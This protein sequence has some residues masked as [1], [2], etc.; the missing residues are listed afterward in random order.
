M[1]YDVP[2]DVPL[3]MDLAFT[4]LPGWPEPDQGPNGPE[5]QDT[6]LLKVQEKN[7][8]PWFA[9]IDVGMM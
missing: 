1:E 9:D 2:S 6:D 3:Q 8:D 4:S 7:S 5:L